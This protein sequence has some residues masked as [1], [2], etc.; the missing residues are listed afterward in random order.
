ML[1]MRAVGQTE[2]TVVADAAVRLGE[3]EDVEDVEDLEMQLSLD[4]VIT[5]QNAGLP[6]QALLEA[7]ATVEAASGGVLRSTLPRRWQ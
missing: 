6:R 2:V 5:R 7:T 4:L 1:S 3:V